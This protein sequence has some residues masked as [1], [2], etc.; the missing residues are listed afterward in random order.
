MISLTGL[1][2]FIETTHSHRGSA[3]PYSAPKQRRIVV[4]KDEK[5]WIM[6]LICTGCSCAVCMDGRQAV[7][8]HIGCCLLHIAV[9]AINVNFRFRTKTWREIN[10]R[11]KR[12]KLHSYWIVW[13]LTAR[14]TESFFLVTLS[15]SRSLCP[16][17]RWYYF[18][19]L[20][21]DMCGYY[22]SVFFYLI[23]RLL[24]SLWARLND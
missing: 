9:P 3:I 24:L 16:F 17:V 6:Y 2:S 12:L 21:L 7:W 1:R 15:Q 11:T 10:W 19:L 22:Y 8:I 5:M 18:I 4:E 13:C 23:I 14:L 20:M